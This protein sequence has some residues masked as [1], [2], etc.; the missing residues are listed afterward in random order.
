MFVTVDKNKMS[1][2]CQKSVGVT[3]EELAQIMK[4]VGCVDA[5]NLD[6]GSSSTMVI[7]NEVVN[8]PS[9]GSEIT[10]SNGIMVR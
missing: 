2:K 10:V 5:M 6:G 9:S 3:L 8:C 7:S 1:E 4:E